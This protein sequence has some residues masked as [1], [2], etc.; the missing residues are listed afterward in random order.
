[1]TDAD[2]LA[3]VVRFQPAR[4]TKWYRSTGTAKSPDILRLLDSNGLDVATISLT[5]KERVRWDYNPKDDAYCLMR[6][7]FAVRDPFGKVLRQIIGPTGESPRCITVTHADGHV[8]A[9]LVKMSHRRWNVVNGASVA[10]NVKRMRRIFD[11]EGAPIARLKEAWG[12]H[13]N[14]VAASPLTEPFA[15]AAVVAMLCRHLG[16]PNSSGG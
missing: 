8:V 16:I 3:R 11:A 6:K 12:V 7:T 9:S 2:E 13:T 10:G 5:G 14:L 1:V 4:A 15:S